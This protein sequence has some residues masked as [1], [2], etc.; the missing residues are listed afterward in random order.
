MEW[1]QIGLAVKAARTAANVKSKDLAEKARI[2]PSTLSKIEKGTQNLDF[3]TAVAIT[4]A[5]NM[6]IDHLASLAKKMGPISV[7]INNDRQELVKTLQELE[8]NMVD[9]ALILMNKK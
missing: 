7:Q 6:S 1:S 9:T 3:S 4:E 2:T 5:L 8:R